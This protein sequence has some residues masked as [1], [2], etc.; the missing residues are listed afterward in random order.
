MGM[1]FPGDPQKWLLVVFGVCVCVFRFPKSFWD[2]VR[3]AGLRIKSQLPTD[4]WPPGSKP[5]IRAPDLWLSLK[6]STKRGGVSPLL[7]GCVLAQFRFTCNSTPSRSLTC[8]SPFLIRT[9]VPGLVQLPF[10]AN[11]K[12][13]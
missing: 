13:K 10:P 5:P 9:P 8:G 1:F 4:W 3:W 7:E 2:N 12:P 6:K 11:P